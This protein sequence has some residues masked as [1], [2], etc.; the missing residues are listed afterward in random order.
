MNSMIIG[1]LPD[2]AATESLLN[3]LAEAEFELRTVSVVMR[4]LKQRAA[5]VEDAGP[6]KGINAS[7]LGRYLAQAGLAS[8]QA[9]VYAAAVQQGKVFVAI[10]LLQSLAATA[11]EMLGDHGA[12]Q[13]REV[14]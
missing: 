3:N 2:V 9:E 10:D 5:L 11:R 14:S 4:D 8:D 6:L 1:L 7:E 13:I 12:Q